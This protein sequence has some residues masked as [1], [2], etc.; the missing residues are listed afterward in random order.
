MSR[1]GEMM[2][3]VWMGAVGWAETE[4]QVFGGWLSSVRSPDSQLSVVSDLLDL[5]FQTVG[6]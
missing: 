1:G 5:P 6:T 4:A 3:W 2:A